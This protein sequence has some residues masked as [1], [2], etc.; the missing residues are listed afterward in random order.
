MKLLQQ[1]RDEIKKKDSTIWEYQTNLT[2][3]I[4]GTH[5]VSFRNLM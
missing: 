2:E 5:K 4:L 3:L 1:L